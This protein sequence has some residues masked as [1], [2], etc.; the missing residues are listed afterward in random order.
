MPAIIDIP[1]PDSEAERA[2]RHT[3]TVVCLSK[4]PPFHPAALK[5]LNISSESDTA[6]DDFE[7]VFRADPAL[8]ADLLLV[9]N[10]ALFG[11]RSKIGSIR[12]ALAHLGLER[13]RALAST[14]A[15]SFFVRNQP[16]TAFVR[17]IWAHSIATALIAET[18]GSL[19]GT[20]DL[21]T[22]GLV[23]DLGR[24][25]LLL[26]V[27]TN[28][29]K[30][31]SADFASM[32][33]SNELEQ[34][35]FGMNHCEAGS[36]VGHKWGFP[37]M[38]RS[39]MIGHHESEQGRPGDPLT[40]VQLACRMA[41]SMGFP[42]IHLQEPGPPPELPEKARKCKELSTERICGRITAQIEA[43]GH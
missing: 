12:Q 19:Y 21:Y 2:A 35:R 24:L 11:V 22:A 1:I 3:E 36:L 6:I 25:G 38:L 30:W 37:V 41:D 29:D 28:Y 17:Q 43:I 34:A 20:P 16:R 27:G 5:L 31:I 33:E 18:L 39:C 7:D 32:G 14:I 42:E 23:H 10:S 26:T 15:L 9:A 4:L 8:T 40:L 13:V